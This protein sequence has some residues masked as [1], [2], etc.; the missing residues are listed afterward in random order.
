MGTGLHTLSLEVIMRRSFP[1]LAVSA[2]LLLAG[3][4]AAQWTETFDSYPTGGIAG[5][6][7]WDG[8]EGDPSADAFVEDS[9]ARSDPNGLAIIDTS[10][11]VHQFDEDSGFWEFTAWQYIPSGGSGQTYF[12]LLN[13]YYPQGGS[14][15]WSLDL[16]FNLNDG[17]IEV[18][19]GT[20]I[21][22]FLTDQWAEIKVEI[23]LDNNL[24]SIYYN[25][26]FLE[27]IPWQTTGV[28][29]IAAVDLFGNGASTV[30]YDDLELVPGVGFDQTTWGSIK[31]ITY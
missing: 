16:K 3:V 27:T 31:S 6:G 8:W 23:D 1:L 25:D 15:D 21:G 17:T 18:V 12:I 28:N 24:Q 9:V 14:H 30:F 22:V 26:G 19:E 7:G 29:E 13:T 20:A 2:V 4:A 10:D 5:T 11:I